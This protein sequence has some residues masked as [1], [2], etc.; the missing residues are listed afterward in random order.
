[1]NA[2]HKPMKIN[3]AQR[4]GVHMSQRNRRDILDS[5]RFRG[6]SDGRRPGCAGF[7]RFRQTLGTSATSLVTSPYAREDTVN[8]VVDDALVCRRHLAP[9]LLRAEALGDEN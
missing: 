8:C 3:I 9:D 4:S 5:N 1:M 2:L 6:L 7:N